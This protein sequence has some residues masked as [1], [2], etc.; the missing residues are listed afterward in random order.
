MFSS[1]MLLG[2]SAQD[3]RLRQ[4]SV[5]AP[6]LEQDQQGAEGEPGDVAP[7]YIIFA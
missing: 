4:C 6:P 5:G 3:G 2:F 1:D 7:M